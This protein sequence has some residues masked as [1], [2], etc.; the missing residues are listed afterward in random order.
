M[1][2]LKTDLRAR[3]VPHIKI[4]LKIDDE[5]A[6]CFGLSEMLRT[7]DEVG[8]IKRAAA[9]LGKSYR[10]VWG[11]I[12]KVENALGVRLVETQI[13]GKG[14]QRSYLTKEAQQLVTDFQAVSYRMLDAVRKEFARRRSWTRT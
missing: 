14:A 5:S 13:G 1:A 12:K 9:E 3:L 8:S 6:I 2:T 11:R 7:I 4:W 10:Y